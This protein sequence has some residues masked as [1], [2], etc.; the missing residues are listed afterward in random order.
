MSQ[1][2]F[3]IAVLFAAALAAR[4]ATVCGQT[5]EQ[6]FQ[7]GNEAYQQGKITEA[8]EIYESIVHNG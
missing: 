6:R 3:L 1:R 4:P 2:H 7:Q 5:P 8:V